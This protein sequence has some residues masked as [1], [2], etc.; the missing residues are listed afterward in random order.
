MQLNLQ[1]NKTILLHNNRVYRWGNHEFYTD[2]LLVTNF[3]MIYIRKGFFGRIKNILKYPLDQVKVQNGQVQ[4]RMAKNF[5]GTPQLQIYFKNTLEF[6]SF[7]SRGKKQILKWVGT[8]HQLLDN[9]AAQTDA[10]DPSVPGSAEED[11]AKARKHPLTGDS[12]GDSKETV[13]PYTTKNCIGCTAPLSGR[14]G[15][16][17]RCEY[18]DTYQIL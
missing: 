14:K 6:F 2:E 16:T 5:R 12:F 1:P 18:C 9:P 4:V 10:F 17:V 15:Q 11:T 7:Q 3:N 8:L 13:P